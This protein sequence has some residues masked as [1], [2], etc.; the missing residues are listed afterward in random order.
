MCG[1][2]KNTLQFSS[3]KKCGSVYTFGFT[4]HGAL[5]NYFGD[6]PI[7]RSKPTLLNLNEDT[8][9]IIK[10]SCGGGKFMI[11]LIVIKNKINNEIMII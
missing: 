1:K 3:F 2:F 5:G 7:A 4:G 8:N 10:I 6:N 9:N 11:Y